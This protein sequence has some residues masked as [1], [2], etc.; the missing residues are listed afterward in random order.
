[1]KCINCGGEINEG[2]PFCPLCG[3]V[4]TN[5]EGS[6]NVNNGQPPYGQPSYEQQQWQSQSQQ[7]YEASQQQQ[8][9]M[10]QQPSYGNESQQWQQPS[11]GQSQPQYGQQFNYGYAQNNMQSPIKKKSKTPLIIGLIVAIL[12][13][14]GLTV[15]IVI[16][17]SN[18]SKSGTR[19]VAAASTAEETVEMFLETLLDGDYSDAADY[20]HPIAIEWYWSGEKS[21]VVEEM[22]DWGPEMSSYDDMSSKRISSSEIAEINAGLEYLGYEKYTFTEGSYVEV[23]IEGPGIGSDNYYMTFTVVKLNGKWYIFD[24][25]D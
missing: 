25:E 13:I 16:I 10:Q 17:V 23:H 4:Q 7:S 3:A 11:Y 12:A 5:V 18:N 9:Y 1:M 20:F 6:E 2:T 15:G 22:E 8:P 24:Y 14:T 19:G 21:E